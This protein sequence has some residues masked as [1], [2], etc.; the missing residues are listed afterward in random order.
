[1][2]CGTRCYK[3]NLSP[4]SGCIRCY[5]DDQ[6]FGFILPRLFLISLSSLQFLC[7]SFTSTLFKYSVVCVVHPSPSPC[8]DLCQYFFCV[9]SVFP[10]PNNGFNHLSLHLSSRMAPVMVSSTTLLWAEMLLVPHQWTS[11]PVRCPRMY[12]AEWHNRSAAAGCFWFTV[13]FSVGGLHRLQL[14]CGWSTY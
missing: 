6:V 4:T 8:A 11:C 12:T 14:N 3:Q 7:C 13:L 2:A 1:M 10:P 9:I 5:A